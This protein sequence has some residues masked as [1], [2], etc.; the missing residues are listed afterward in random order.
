MIDSSAMVTTKIS[1]IPAQAGIQVGSGFIGITW[2]SAFA[3]M[4]DKPI[5]LLFFQAGTL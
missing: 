4:T 1:V 3:G 5:R 2:I